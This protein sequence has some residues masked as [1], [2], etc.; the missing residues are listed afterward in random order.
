MTGAS[1]TKARELKT[2]NPA[3]EEVINTYEI[4][5]K[6]QINE[7]VKKAQNAFSDWKKDIQK[8]VD[9]IHDFAQELRKNKEELART[10]TNE[11]GKA[12]K[13]ARSEVEK[14]AWVMDYFA[15]NGKV[16]T[17]DEVVN[18]DARRSFVTFEPLGVIG[19]IM[20]W[21]FPYWQALRFAAPSLM[22]GNAIVLKPASATMQCGIEIEKT[23]EKAGLADG[24]F[25]TLVGDSSIADI[26]IDSEDVNAITFT[27]SVPVGGKV[28]QRATSQI[29]KCVLELGGS[30]P[31]IVCEDAN[32]EKAS[33]GAVKGRFINCGQSCIA[34]KRF[35][36]VKKIANEFIE[37]FVQGTEKLKV[38]DPLSDD[39]DVGPLV[40][41]SGLKTIDFQV[42]DSVKEGAEL[43]AGGEQIKSKGYFYKPT[44]LKNVSPNMRVAQ[45]EVF[46][47][48][49]P[50]IIADSEIEALRLAND[51]QYGL[52]AS[53]WTEDLDKAEELSRMVR[54]GIVTVNNVVIS[55]P[56]VPF[57][58]VKKSGFGR[59]LSRYGMLEFVNIKSVRF[60]DQLVHQHHVE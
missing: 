42:K 54:S 46:G 33:N 7:K 35:I 9:H 51:S 10:V 39:T 5:T 53:I 22:V 57:G 32:V 58:G 23:F 56:R 6:E 47:P 11:M 2:I 3:T 60:Y 27:G 24:V 50:I 14:C 26:L 20:P 40:N 41:A 38:G 36:V 55:D 15:D 43:L 19:S 8:R 48:V 16:F 13:E 44:S 59:E 18:T 49:A 34:S 30:D 37:K 1:S 52:G 4:M 45:E 31:F 17:T 28:A 25:Q 12:I 29:K 21:N